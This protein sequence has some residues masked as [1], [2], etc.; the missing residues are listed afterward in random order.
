[1]ELILSRHAEAEPAS[2]GQSDMDRKL[3]AKGK[4]QASR[5]GEWLDNTLP[6][7]CKIL[8]SPAL[9]TLQTA[10]GLGRKFKTDPKLSP[11]ATLDDI[12]AAANWPNSS[13]PVLIVG[14]QP[15]LGQVI[16]WLVSGEKNEWALRKANVCWITN[17]KNTEDSQLSY[18]KAII[19]PDL[20][21]KQ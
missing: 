10:K 13:T 18:I 21:K 1:M 19:G 16:S 11:G 5:M 12:L 4:K 17:A 14:H 8:A 20:V 3:T 6:E 9:R 2:F 15:T 7:G